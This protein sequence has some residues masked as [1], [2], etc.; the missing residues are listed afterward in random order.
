MKRG[1]SARLWARVVS[2]AVFACLASAAADAEEPA[3]S[4][5]ESIKVHGHW[6]LEIRNPDGTLDARHEIENAQMGSPLLAGLLG[7][8]YTDASWGI[9]LWGDPNP[10]NATDAGQ[11][12]CEIGQPPLT[13]T[14]PTAS[15]SPA[16]TVE[17]SGSVT[18]AQDSRLFNVNSIW[19]AAIRGTTNRAFNQFSEKSIN[20]QVRRGQVVQVK[21][22]F[23]FS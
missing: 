11:N 5:G 23:S 8:V 19:S 21:V 14:I 15:G 20:I 10:C 22:V 6:T 3:R 13:V 7:N 18:I 12:P 9:R 2:A 1:Q 4:P 16:G 17:L